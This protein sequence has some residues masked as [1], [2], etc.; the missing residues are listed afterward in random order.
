MLYQS[1][2]QL[3]TR[4]ARSSPC[5][6]WRRCCRGAR[7]GRR[8]RDG[9][10]EHALRHATLPAELQRRLE[11]R[12]VV[13]SILYSRSTIAKDSSTPSTSRSCRPC[14]RRS[15]GRTRPTDAKPSTSART[16]GTSKAWTRRVAPAAR[17]S[18]A[19]TTRPEC[20]YQH[21][22][23]QWD[24]VMWDNRAVLH[25]GGRWDARSIAA[26]C[27]GRTLGRRGSTA[28]P[29][30][31][32][33]RPRGTAHPEGRRRLTRALPESWEWPIREPLAGGGLPPADVLRRHVALEVADRGS[34]SLKA[35]T[36]DAASRSRRRRRS[37]T[38][39]PAIRRRPGV[40]WRHRPIDRIDRPRDQQHLIFP[41]LDVD[42]GRAGS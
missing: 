20:V 7:S 31:R 16:P 36:P 40:L 32:R 15:C 37:P 14:A 11:G 17:R 25:R 1:G 29:S 4:T 41:V 19:H 12:V 28:D 35:R 34:G 38:R 33:A 39:S 8:R 9:V 42:L 23:R 13:H 3:C 22:W 24:L 26:S 30:S 21:R 18:L 5:R 27:A 10:R 6:R 2:N